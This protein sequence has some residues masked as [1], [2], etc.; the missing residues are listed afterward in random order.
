MQRTRRD[1]LDVDRAVGGLDRC[2]GR[3]IGERRGAAIGEDRRNGVRQRE[4]DHEREERD[5]VEPGEGDHGDILVGERGALYPCNGTW[6]IP[7][8]R[9]AAIHQRMDEPEEY[10]DWNRVRAFL[11]TAEKG[12]L[13][14]AARALGTTQPTVG[15]QIA[16][17]EGE[18]GVVLFERVGRGLSIT[19]SGERLLEQA[20]P[21]GVAALR[22]SL[23]ATGVNEA[24]DGRVTVTASDLFCA[25]SMPPLLAELRREAPGL[26]IEVLASNSVRDLLRREADVAVRHVEPTEGELI[27]RRTRQRFAHFYA[28]RED[29]ERYDSARTAADL[30][31]EH[32]VGFSA[33]A[34][35]TAAHLAR[36]FGL[37]VTARNVPV[38]TESGVL[39]RE[40]V[41]EG[42]GLGILPAEVGDADPRLARL[43]VPLPEADYPTWVV[44][45][46]ELHQS[47][48]IR[49]VFD[50]MVRALDR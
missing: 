2:P 17:L 26:T 43:P 33:R 7:R 18:L 49:L 21:M 45:H 6:D 24:I 32:F 39:M 38:T 20:R 46:R 44:T 1:E 9:L 15:R 36:E 37:P 47:V 8:I 3:R 10:F 22:L 42:L 23:A 48:R 14:A 50:L 27:A 11:L 34:E 35:Q 41:A 5:P 29:L 30:G 19:P 16:A 28:R 4:Q 31:D 25:V 13:S 40:L 12:S